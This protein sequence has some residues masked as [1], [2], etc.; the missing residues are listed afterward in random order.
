MPRKKTNHNIPSR[1]PRK[2]K[3]ADPASKYILPSNIT[4]ETGSS[5]S[6]V[7]RMEKA[8]LFPRRLLLSLNKTGWRREDVEAWQSA[9]Q[10]RNAA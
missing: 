3:P 9:R 1:H 5:L 10:A 8:G 2:F 7:Y 6:T 4:F